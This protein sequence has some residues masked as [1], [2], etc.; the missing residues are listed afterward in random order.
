MT[1]HTEITPPLGDG[2]WWMMQCHTCR[3][4]RAYPSRHRA[5]QVRDQ[6][7]AEHTAGTVTTPALARLARSMGAA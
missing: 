2:T 6:H 3:E 4:V 5:E 1:T 7:E